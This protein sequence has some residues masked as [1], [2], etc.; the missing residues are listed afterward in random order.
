MHEEPLRKGEQTQSR[1]LDAAYA[2]FME[3]GYHGTSMRQIVE[4][5]GITMGGVYNH[6]ASK[7]DIWVAVLFDRHPYRA[8]VP[9]LHAAEGD[10]A[11]AFVRD[12][13]RR[14]V[15]ELSQRKD[16]LH[17]MFI[18]LIEFNG[19]HIPALYARIAPELVPLLDVVRSRAE[20]LRALPLPVLARSFLGF[21]FSYYVT[22]VLMPPAVRAM[23]SGDALDAF[24]DIYLHGVLVVEGASCE[25]RWQNPDR[26]RGPTVIRVLFLRHSR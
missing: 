1:I 12:A 26:Q 14:L 11:E 19:V 25:G 18:E 9:M 15:G 21:F 10:T 8:V 16:L 13:A 2:L 6:F 20:G 24:L 23:M 22:D 5:A 4:R 7:E 17:I 3:Q